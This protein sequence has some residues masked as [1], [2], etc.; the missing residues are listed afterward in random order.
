[1]STILFLVISL[2][3]IG[4]IVYLLLYYD[5]NKNIVENY[6]KLAIQ[7][8][9]GPLSSLLNGSGINNIPNLNITTNNPVVNSANTCSEIPAFI[10]LG[11]ATDVDCKRTC[12]NESAKA[13]NVGPGET[14]LYDKSQLKVGA[15]CII[16]PRPECNMKTSIA[17]MTLNS[18]VCQSKFPRLVAGPL[19]NHIVGC[20][21]SIINDP[22][23]ILWDFKTNS[24]FNPW[25][26]TVID[27]N[28]KLADGSYRF[29]C[30]FKG[31]DDHGNEF[32]AH[33]FDRLHPIRNY[34]SHLV[35]RAHPDVKTVWSDTDKTFVCDCGNP[36]V[37]RVRNLYEDDPTSPCSEIHTTTVDDIKSRKILSVPYKCF[38]MY[39]PIDDVGKYIPCPSEQFTRNG[40]QMG[41]VQVALTENPNALIEHPIYADLNEDN[42]PNVKSGV[43]V[44]KHLKIV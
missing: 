24:R 16:G 32:Q 5:F 8:Y 2:S 18:V 19:G 3:V 23:N 26:T 27:E 25:T 39:S 42:N 29:S 35:Y 14:V 1:M 34:C 31:V 15:H 37:T 43:S 12:V 22:Q 20:N 11:T 30:H 13:I 36:Q 38:T 9:N 40:S 33:P 28:E 44:Q 17:L 4:F 10:G 6:K 7:L 41:V 21:N